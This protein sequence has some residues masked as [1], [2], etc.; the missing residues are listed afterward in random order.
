MKFIEIGDPGGT[1]LHSGD[2]VEWDV[3]QAENARV[4]RLGLTPAEHHV[5]GV[6]M[7]MFCAWCGAELG[8]KLGGGHGICSE[9]YE[10]EFRKL[11]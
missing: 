1:V 9:C 3:F 7:M 10:K 6:M 2:I 4:L 8:E 5:S 11:G